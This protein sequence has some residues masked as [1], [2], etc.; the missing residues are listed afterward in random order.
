MKVEMLPEFMDSMVKKKK[1]KKENINRRRRIL[2][3]T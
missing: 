3:Y 2:N 1:K